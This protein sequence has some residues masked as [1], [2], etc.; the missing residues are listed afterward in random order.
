VRERLFEERL[1][2]GKRELLG[3]A[4]ESLP[5]GGVESG[6]QAGLVFFGESHG[7][8]VEVGEQLRE[9]RGNGPG[10]S[11]GDGRSGSRYRGALCESGTDPS[12]QR[13]ENLCKLPQ[14]WIDCVRAGPIPQE[15]LD[16]SGRSLHRPGTKAARHPLQGVSQARGVLGIVRG[17]R[18]AN[19]PDGVGL[20]A[21]ELAQQLRVEL[22]V[23]ADTAESVRA[24][25]ALNRREVGRRGAGSRREPRP[26]REPT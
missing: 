9:L 1:S 14:R 10:L 2:V 16:R 21:C 26:Q 6:T 8:G 3:L 19:L 20:L 7:A 5:R 18:R 12:Q 15:F 11:W 24:I 22:P 25:E 13:N 4:E 17:Q 23:A